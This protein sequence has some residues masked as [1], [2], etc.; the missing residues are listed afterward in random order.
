MTG[1]AELI[2]SAIENVVRNAIRHTPPG[3]VVD[4]TIERHGSFALL[5][6]S[7]C[8][9][10]VPPEMLEKIFLPFHR[11]DNKNSGAGLGLAIA[12]RVIKMHQGN[13]TAYNSRGGGLVVEIQLPLI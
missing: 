9:P 11:V 4:V 12:D 5:R 6:I 3:T 13:I 1:V 2:R 10:G 8:G 7:D